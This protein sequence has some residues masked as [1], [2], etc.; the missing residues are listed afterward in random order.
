MH[1][2][3]RAVSLTDTYCCPA[4]SGKCVDNVGGI[5]L[6]I[7]EEWCLRWLVK[8]RYKRCGDQPAHSGLMRLQSSLI[9]DDLRLA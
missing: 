5:H 3:L 9:V 7:R 4:E 1:A 8:S 2:L 6:S